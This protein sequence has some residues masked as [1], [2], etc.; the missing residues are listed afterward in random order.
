MFKTHAFWCTYHSN[1]CV[2]IRVV[3]KSG[4]STLV[5]CCYGAGR[6]ASLEKKGLV[7]SMTLISSINYVD[8]HAYHYIR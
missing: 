6:V 2:H 3:L 7:L 5:S 1:V 4:L 8:S